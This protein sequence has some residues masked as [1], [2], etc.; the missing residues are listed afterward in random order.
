[1]EDELARPGADDPGRLRISDA[2]RHRVAEVLREAAGD[3]RLD[4]DE[5][6]ERLEATY[7]AKVYADLVPIV[8]DLPGSQLDLLTPGRPDRGSGLSRPG[9]SGPAARHDTSVAI[10]GGQDRKGVWEVGPRHTAFALMGGIT[11]DLRQAVFT[12][13][14]VVIIAATVMG[15][16][17][18]LVNEHT[19]VVVEGVGIMGAFDQ[20]RDRVEA[21]LDESSPVVRVKG[22]A[23]MGGVTVTRRP[24]P[25]GSGLLPRRGH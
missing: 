23:L 15:G 5:L 9:V 24:M 21:R 2:D 17:D 16:I 25:G 22:V 12:A 19:K 3:G 4:L 8:V 20:A 13:P 18:V 1:M 6:D 14:E 10:L 7:A 11:L